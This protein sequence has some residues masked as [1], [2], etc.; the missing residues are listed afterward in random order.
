MVLLGHILH[1]VIMNDKWFYQADWV[2]SGGNMSYSVILL[3]IGYIMKYWV[4]LG[5]NELYQVFLVVLDFN[6]SYNDILGYNELYW[7]LMGRI[8]I[9]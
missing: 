2:L 1:W 8:V 4:T 9:F 7:G 3:I 6:G 5:Y